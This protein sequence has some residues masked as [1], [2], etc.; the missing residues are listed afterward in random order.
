M[1]NELQINSNNTLNENLDLTQKTRMMTKTFNFKTKQRSIID[2]EL[3]NDTE[4]IL[5]DKAKTY[6]DNLNPSHVSNNPKSIL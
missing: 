3:D 2:E 6:I 1:N 4:I 5:E